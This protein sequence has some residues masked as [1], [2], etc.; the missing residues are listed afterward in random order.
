[1]HMWTSF[2]SRAFPQEWNWCW[3]IFVVFFHSLGKHYR[4]KLLLQYVCVC[5]CA[6]ACTC[7]RIPESFNC[8][9]LL[10]PPSSKCLVQAFLHHWASQKLNK[11][12]C[13]T[14]HC[15]FPFVV[16]EYNRSNVFSLLL[17]RSTKILSF[18]YWTVIT[19]FVRKHTFFTFDPLDWCF[20]HR[21]WF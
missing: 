1:M 20:Q 11:C 19:R 13:W 10:V 7:V 17:T 18:F 12:L 5:A 8:L 2:F 16:S 9:C 3:H 6:R 14:L 4:K 21:V 15:N